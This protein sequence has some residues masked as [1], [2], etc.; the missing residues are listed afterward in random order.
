MAQRLLLKAAAKELQL[1]EHF[2]RSE[3]RAGRMPHIKVGNRYVFDIEIVNEH[4]KTKAMR[5]MNKEC[6]K[7]DIPRR[8]IM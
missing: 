2:L 7:G 6:D 3:A 5:S 1:S 4:L 8:R